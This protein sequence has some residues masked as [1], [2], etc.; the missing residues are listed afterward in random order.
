MISTV[1]RLRLAALLGMLGSSHAGERENAARLVE[2]FRRQRGLNWSDLLALQPASDREPEA[3]SPPRQEKSQQLGHAYGSRERVWRWSMLVGLAVVGLM[4]LTSLAQQ[5]AAEKRMAAQGDVGCG[6]GAC[7]ATTDGVQPPI[8]HP[9]VIAAGNPA[10]SKGF[11]QGLADRQ[12]FEGWRSK[13]PTGLCT[14]RSADE[15]AWKSD[16]AIVRKLLA[17]FEQRRRADSDYRAGWNSL[18]R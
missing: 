8:V 16:C 11:V 5:H 18:A 3:R 13:A 17:Q 1:D 10:T 4:S 6:Q 7:A 2:Q 15:K 12:V 14:G 9:T